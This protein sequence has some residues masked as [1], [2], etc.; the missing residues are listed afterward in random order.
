M[1]MM[2]GCAKFCAVLAAMLVLPALCG[3]AESLLT[4][5]GV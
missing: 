5:L 2:I 1:K 3:L 4:A